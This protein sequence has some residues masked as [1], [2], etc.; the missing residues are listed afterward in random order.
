[1][2]S[3]APAPPEPTLADK[4]E[5]LRSNLGLDAAVVPQ[6]LNKACEEL[7][8]DAAYPNLTAKADACLEAAGLT[9][10][11]G[12]ASQA[13]KVSPAPPNP[14]LVQPPQPSPPPQPGFVQP[15]ITPCRPSSSRC[16]Q[17]QPCC[18]SRR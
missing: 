4:V 5:T 18:S 9:A 6:I 2:A 3:I 16:S 13:P 11:A 12:A 15:N 8:L 7:G 10:L 17:H 14:A 1:M